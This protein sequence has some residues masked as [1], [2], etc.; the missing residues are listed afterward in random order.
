M[1]LL[2]QIHSRQKIAKK[3]G[4]T[5]IPI[6]SPMQLARLDVLLTVLLRSFLSACTFAPTNQSRR[7]RTYNAWRRNE[8]TISTHI[9]TRFICSVW[10]KHSVNQK[11]ACIT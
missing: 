7:L 8:W 2:L 3:V 10:P 6:L 9:H 5:W 1:A 4:N 11:S